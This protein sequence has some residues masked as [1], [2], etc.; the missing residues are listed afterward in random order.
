MSRKSA[1]KRSKIRW[2]IFIVILLVLFG[3]VLAYT[4][5]RVQYR[6]TQYSIAT[7]RAEGQ[8][9]LGVQDNLKI[10]LAR[11]RSPERIAKYAREQCRL[12][13]PATGQFRN[14]P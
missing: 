13:M 8:R 6:S 9:L 5:C 11:L 7:L 10:E 14:L 1:Q 12:A 2:F 4:W 3:E